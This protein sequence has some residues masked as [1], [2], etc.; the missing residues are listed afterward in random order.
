[1]RIAIAAA[2][3]L[4]AAAQPRFDPDTAAWWKTAAQLSNDGMEGR[5]TGSAAYLRA[6]RLVAARFQAAGL[7]PAGDNGGWFQAVPMHEIRVDRATISTGKQ[8]LL[9]LHALTVSPAV[10][11]P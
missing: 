9:F 6:A 8:P 4:T 3:L 2:M 7:R 1:M 11:M 5:D 10:G